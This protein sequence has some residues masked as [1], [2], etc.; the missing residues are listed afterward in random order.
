MDNYLI[1]VIYWIYIEGINCYEDSSNNNTSTELK[2]A[3][4]IILFLE[5][6]LI[7]SRTKTISKKTFLSGKLKI[8]LFNIISHFAELFVLQQIILVC[9]IIFTRKVFPMKTSLSKSNQFMIQDNFV[10]LKIF[11]QIYMKQDGI[12]FNQQSK[13]IYIQFLYMLLSLFLA[14]WFKSWIWINSKVAISLFNKCF[15]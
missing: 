6:S 15:A 1:S 9:Y 4:V 7:I 3:Q 5:K 2:K 13:Y 12:L 11:D 8:V 14:Q 10:V